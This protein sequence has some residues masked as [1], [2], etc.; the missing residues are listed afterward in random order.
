M[1]EY[2]IAVIGL[3]PAGAT[4]ARMLDERFKVIAIDKKDAS[5]KAGFQK[6]CGGLLASDAQKALS[7]FN[8]TLPKKLLMDPQ[9]FAVKTIDLKARIKRYYQRFYMNM[10]RHAFDLWLMSLIKQNVTVEDNSR[11]CKIEREDRRF[12][13]TY[14]KG[15]QN[16]EN[17]IFARFV[18]GADGANSIVRNTFFKHRKI[19]KYL[20]IQQW[21]VDKNARP[22]YSCFFD[23][24]ITD[25]YAW[26]ISKDGNFIVGGA[27]PVK[28]ATARF[29][30]LKEKLRE[31]GYVFGEP[32]KTEACMVMRPFGLLEHCPGSGGA[33]LLGEAAGLISPSSL[34]GI[35]YAFES[36]AILAEVFNLGKGDLNRRYNR[37]LFK[38]RIKLMVKNVKSF[39]MYFPLSRWFIM[40]IGLQAIKVKEE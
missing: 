28:T 24:D 20:S 1:R 21:F 7:Q 14:N 37:K 40:K 26:S 6:P 34:E 31:H 10:D 35:S 27:F 9:I 32:V 18:V 19:R 15:N 4:F 39:F 17:V 23:R 3:G 8:L 22:L 33:F 25:C 5:G 29:E 13:I 12:K 36:G 16:E 2:D 30:M 11:C 38:T